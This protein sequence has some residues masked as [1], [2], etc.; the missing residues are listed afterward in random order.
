MY[1]CHSAEILSIVVY[2]SR[3]QL[4]KQALNGLLIV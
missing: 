2:E 3:L 4:L 1:G